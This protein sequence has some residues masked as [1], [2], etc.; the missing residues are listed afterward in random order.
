[1]FF[2][3]LA[4]AT[5]ENSK[6][7]AKAIGVAHRTHVGLLDATGVNKLIPAPM[8]KLTDGLYRTNQKLVLGA[9]HKGAKFLRKLE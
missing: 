7:S 4:D 5:E 9:G 1:M 6:L 2:N 3:I 8:K